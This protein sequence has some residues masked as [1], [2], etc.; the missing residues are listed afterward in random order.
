MSTEEKELVSEGLR[1]V[2]SAR[3]GTAG[4]ISAIATPLEGVSM[5]G[6]GT[7]DIDR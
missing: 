1:T 5:R 3:T 2:R 7:G 4:D 6:L